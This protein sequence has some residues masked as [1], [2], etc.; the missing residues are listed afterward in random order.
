M[1]SRAVSLHSCAFLPSLSGGSTRHG[2]DMGKGSPSI[3]EALVKNCFVEFALR[4]EAHG[5]LTQIRRVFAAF[6]ESFLVTNTVIDS[7]Q[8]S[9]VVWIGNAIS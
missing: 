7:L 2:R 4:E 3:T 5:E 9:K 8:Q 6:G 1:G